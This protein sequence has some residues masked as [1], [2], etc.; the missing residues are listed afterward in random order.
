MPLE[1]LHKVLAHAGFGSRRSCERL[2]AEGKVRVDGKVITEMG[3]KVDP[4]KQRVQCGGQV[5]RAPARIVLALNKPKHVVSTVR[6]E[7]GRKTV[8]D[9]LRGRFKERLY[10]AGRLDAD[11]SGLIILTNDGD[12]ANRLTHP[13]YQVRKT[14]HVQLKGELP[15][16]IV[17]RMAQGVWLSEGKTGPMD[18][19]IK[20][21][22]RELTVVE[23]QLREGMNREIRRVFAKF[24]LKVKRLRRIKIG[25]LALGTLPEGGF[26]VLDDRDLSLML[27]AA[28]TPERRPQGGARG[29]E[30][31][32]DREPAADRGSEEE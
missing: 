28:A 17:K 14:Y 31:G 30:A 29:R 24:G 18:V 1:R 3:V 11:S 26:R 20:K 6:D 32:E 16:D 10:P 12:L 13:R 23:V 27:G 19:K 15:P 25:K 22:E 2:I 8:I 4:A 21:T 9:C 7:R 5:L